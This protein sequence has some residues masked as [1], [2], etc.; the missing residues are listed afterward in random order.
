MTFY[1]DNA[2]SHTTIFEWARRFKDEKLTIN[3]GY[4]LDH[5]MFDSPL[6]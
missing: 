6:S 3:D 4:C 2:P 5:D 1:S